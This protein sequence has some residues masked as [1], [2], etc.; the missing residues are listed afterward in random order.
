MLKLLTWLS[1][2]YVR[3]P[4]IDSTLPI[5]TLP[6]LAAPVAMTTLPE[7]VVHAASA[8]APAGLLMVVVEEKE[9]L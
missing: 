7:T 4:S 2:R 8:L 1:L 3:A 9:Q 5:S 6:P